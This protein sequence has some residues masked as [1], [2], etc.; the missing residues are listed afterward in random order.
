[1]AFAAGSRGAGPAQRSPRAHRHKI[2]ARRPAA[3]FGAHGFADGAMMRPMVRPQHRRLESPAEVREF[4]LGRVEIYEIGDAVVGRQIFEPGWRWSESVGLIAGTRLCE[5]HHQGYSFQGNARIELED[6]SSFEIGPNEAYEIPPGHDAWV[7]GDDAW[8]AIDWAGM[9][10]FARPTI[11]S[12]ERVLSTILFT[13]IVD[14]TATAVQLGD[15]AWR[16]L[17]AQHNERGRSELDRFRGRE[18]DTTG[19]GFLA[20]FDSSER[21]V[22]AAAAICLAA[23]AMGI[24]T[25]AGVHTGEV[26]LVPGDVRGVAVHMAARIMALAGPSEVLVSGTTHELLAGSGLTFEDRGLHELKGI[27][28]ARQVFALTAD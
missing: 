8:I 13:D 10:S 6:G 28:G 12:G 21:A 3:R 4:P 19:D 24:Q 5:Y 23:K 16:E 17:L 25:R 11:G 26:E 2:A 1:M 27:S 18:I 9:R 7:V 15:A 22:R 14:S 20:L